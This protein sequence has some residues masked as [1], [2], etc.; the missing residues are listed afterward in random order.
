MEKNDKIY[1][2]GHKGMLGYALCEKLKEYGFNNVFGA[3]LPEVD[4]CN[5]KQTIDFFVREKPKYVFFLAAVAGGIEY[6][7]KYPADMLLK[8]VEMISNVFE[9]SKATNVKKLIN[10][11]SA[12]LYPKDTVMPFSEESVN[13]ADLDIIDTPYS[14]AKA[15]GMALG[16]YFNS[17]FGTD[18]LTVVPCN[19]FGPKACFEGDKAG[20]VPS[21]IKK[22][23]DAKTNHEEYVT[24]WGTGNACREFLS[25]YDVADALV[26][27]MNNKT[28]ESLIN[29][30]R[31]K[32][33][34]IKETALLISKLVGYNGN[35]IFDSSKP[36]GRMH[37]QLDVSKLAKYGW[38]PKLDLSRSVELTIAWYKE[39]KQ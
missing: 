23:V 36:E 13:K 15:Y 19:F 30:A 31:G 25:S 16:N 29:I 10:I 4:L 34:S 12:L 11:S 14:L 3:D 17:Q 37:M 8:N 5:Q 35:V 21:L 20:V 38:S 33:F 1:V 22:F 39:N 26:F 7:K 18:Y 32:E 24:V 6:K 9:A 28:E 27:L 2:L